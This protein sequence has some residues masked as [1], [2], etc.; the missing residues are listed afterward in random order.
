MPP[1][2]ISF[3]DPSALPRAQ[4]VFR[5]IEKLGADPQDL[6]YAWGG[7]LEA[8]IRR[9]FDTGIGPGGVPW[10]KSYRAWQEG[11]KTLV[12]SGN[13]ENSVRF[14]VRPREFEVGIDGVGESAKFAYVHQFGATIVPRTAGALVFPVPGGGFMTASRVTIP[15]RPMIG[16]DEQDKVDMR[17]VAIDILRSIASG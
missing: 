10:P 1:V 3:R 14:E 16:V 5:A 17:E 7:V 8:S 11:G 12:D 2:Q 6:L 13:L 9:R 4:K 15:R